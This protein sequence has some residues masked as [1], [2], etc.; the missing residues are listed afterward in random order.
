MCVP[1]NSELVRKIL[2]EAHNSTMFAHPGNN[3]MYNDLKKICWWPIMKRVKAE[4]QLPSGLLQP[5]SIPEWKWERI[6]MDFVSGLPMSPR[7]KDA[8][9]VIVDQLTKSAHFIPIR[10]DFSLDI[11]L[12]CIFLRLLDYMGYQFLLSPIEIPGLHPDFGINCKKHWAH[13]CILALHFILK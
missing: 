1:K 7:K 9:W 12:N 2:H 3:K 11:W 6:T 10:M 8:I 13:S 4:H 5:V